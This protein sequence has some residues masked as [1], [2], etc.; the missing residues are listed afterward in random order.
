MVSDEGSVGIFYVRPTLVFHD[1]WIELFYQ[2]TYTC[3]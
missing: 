1:N 2:N 3:C